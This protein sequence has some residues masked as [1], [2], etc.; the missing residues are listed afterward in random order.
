MSSETVTR[1]K[2]RLHNKAESNSLGFAVII[3]VTGDLEGRVIVDM[4]QATAIKF[5][6]I[7]NME[8]I[9]EFNDLV[10]SSMGEIGNMI[11]GRAIS[12]L[13]N[14]GGDFNITPP[15][16]FE[17]ENMI[18]STPNALPII[19]VPLSV[20]FGHIDVNLALTHRKK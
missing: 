1:G 4:S 3:G 9:G 5:A 14:E 12:K 2:L 7:M 10:K 19:V 17:G 16:L 15:T 8:E 18:V 11:S 20:P 6:E 13:Q